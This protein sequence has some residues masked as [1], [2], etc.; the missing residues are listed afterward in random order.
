MKR[1]AYLTLVLLTLQ[2]CASTPKPTECEVLSHATGPI[3]SGMIAVGMITGSLPLVE[4]TSAMAAM[5][6]R[7][8]KCPKPQYITHAQAQ[9]MIAQALEQDRAARQ[10]GDKTPAISDNVDVA[11]QYENVAP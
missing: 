7:H 1:I 6:Y 10:A 4:A 11:S 5:G 8:N 3:G 2:G 9:E